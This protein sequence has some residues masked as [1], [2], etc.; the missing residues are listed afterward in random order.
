MPRFKAQY[1]KNYVGNNIKRLRESLPP[2][3]TT[4]LKNNR[5]DRHMTQADFAKALSDYMGMSSEK[6]YG[7]PAVSS[8][9][10]GRSLPPIETLSKIAEFF[11]ISLEEL[12]RPCDDEFIKGISDDIKNP[13][14]F[15][16]DKY[17]VP[18][19]QI[20]AYHK[21]PIYVH[22][23][24]MQQNDEWGIVDVLKKQIIFI[25]NEPLDIS[26]RSSLSNKYIFYAIAPYGAVEIQ[27]RVDHPLSI[28]QVIKQKKVW[29]STC[30][31]DPY[32][33]GRYDGWYH[34]NKSQTC[35]IN[36]RGDILPLEGMNYSFNCYTDNLFK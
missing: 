33:K 36:V 26:N 3:E 16:P 27:Y 4:E 35:L 12:C 20:G 32:V 34:I 25:D 14:V 17:I 8:W 1:D 13:S 9:E 19:T 5:K 31:H 29:V 15:D 18:P 7:I 2:L 6:R 22:F 23:N 24:G 28:S 21:K 11:H 30:S 10:S